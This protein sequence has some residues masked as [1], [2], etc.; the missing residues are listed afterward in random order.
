MSCGLCS[1]SGGQ[2][3]LLWKGEAKQ[4]W[5]ERKERPI[6]RI[7]ELVEKPK[8]EAAGQIFVRMNK[9]LTTAREGEGKH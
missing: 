5:G 3:R 9:A 7:A 4:K 1:G 2:G 8:C 6:L